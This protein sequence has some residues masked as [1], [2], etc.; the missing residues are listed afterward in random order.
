MGK[1]TQTTAE[2]QNILNKAGN[3]P[4]NKQVFIYVEDWKFN[5]DINLYEAT[6]TDS[7]IIDGSVI[8]GGV[9]VESAYDIE[10]WKAAEGITGLSDMYS[11]GK[12]D[13]YAKNQPTGGFYYK[14][15]I[16]L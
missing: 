6:V 8:F 1:L 9:N 16:Q 12:F 14:Y 7:D 4:K 11:V 10:I 3:Y 2:V 5:I 13:V 15:T